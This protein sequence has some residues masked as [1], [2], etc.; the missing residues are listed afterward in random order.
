MHILQC[1]VQYS[2]THIER[3]YHESQN[4]SEN[5]GELFPR[6]STKLASDSLF[7]RP[8]SHDPSPSVAPVSET[9]PP[10]GSCKESNAVPPDTRCSCDAVVSVSFLYYFNP[11]DNMAR[12]AKVEG[13]TPS[14]NNQ[15]LH[16]WRPNGFWVPGSTP[17][18][19]PLS[20]H[21]GSEW[22]PVFSALPANRGRRRGRSRSA[23]RTES[24]AIAGAPLGVANKNSR[25]PEIFDAHFP[26]SPLHPEARPFRFCTRP[27]LSSSL[28][29]G[30]N[31]RP[32]LPSPLFPLIRFL[33]SSVF[34]TAPVLSTPSPPPRKF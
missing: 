25:L 27:L 2:T 17:F 29:T 31:S 15:F 19:P 26:P 1:V 32:H 12:N 28:F 16:R 10:R 23:P 4:P 14:R 8:H 22:S 30:A 9:P 5:A 18:P 24:D 11:R 7:R 20:S 21:S 6:L 3:Y 34:S 13:S 33:G